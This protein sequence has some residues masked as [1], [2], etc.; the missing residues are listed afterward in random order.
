MLLG[1]FIG[2]HR[3]L[4]PILDESF[5]KAI[6]KYPN[7]Q[8]SVFGSSSKQLPKPMLVEQ[9]VLVQGVIEPAF[10]WTLSPNLDGFQVVNKLAPKELQ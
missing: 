1:L 9:L 4:N 7:A 6:Q 8:A 2:E 10:A 5:I 3:I